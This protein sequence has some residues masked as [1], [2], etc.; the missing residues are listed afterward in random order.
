MLE[1]AKC[2]FFEILR[3]SWG[4]SD[5]KSALEKIFFQKIEKIPKLFSEN[6]SRTDL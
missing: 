1:S 2:S 6:F 3:K 4:T 5:Y